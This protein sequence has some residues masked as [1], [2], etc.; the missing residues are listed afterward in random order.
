MTKFHSTPYSIN[1][2]HEVYVK[3]PFLSIVN[4]PIYPEV[5]RP[6]YQQIIPVGTT[7]LI[8]YRDLVVP[9]HF[10]LSVPIVPWIT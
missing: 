2:N 6:G 10:L 9:K 1:G 3:T 7:V 8:A 4:L 5:P